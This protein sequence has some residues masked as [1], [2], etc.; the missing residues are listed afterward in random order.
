M[1]TPYFRP[2][3]YSFGH[4][5]PHQWGIDGVI[6]ER[7]CE[8]WGGWKVL[9][10]GVRRVFY[11]LLEEDLDAFLSR[12]RWLTTWEPR[13]LWYRNSLFVCFLDKKIIVKILAFCYSYSCYSCFLRGML[14]SISYLYIYILINYVI[15]RRDVCPLFLVGTLE[16]WNATVVNQH[17]NFI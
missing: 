7:A 10:G 16:R 14:V 9:E 12:L 6:R 3:G 8:R 15:L 13:V 11:G 2:R 4:K 5:N 17:L 1:G